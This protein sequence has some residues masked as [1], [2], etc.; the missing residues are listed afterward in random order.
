MDQKEL[1]ELEA[2]CIQEE[3][4]A[5]KAGC[6][7][8]VDGRGFSQAMARGELDVARN[9]LEKAMPLSRILARLCEAPCEQFCIRKNLG[10]S[11]NIS[12][13]ENACIVNTTFKRKILKLPPRQKKTAVIGSGP[14][15]LTVAFDLAKK[16]YQINVYHASSKPGGWLCE[17][18]EE[19]LPGKSRS[20]EISRLVALG[21][22]FNKVPVLDDALLANIVADAVY[23]AQDDVLT[24]SLRNLLKSPDSRTFALS[25]PGRFTGGL[26]QTD[27]PF[28]IITDIFQGREAALSID[29][30]LQGVSLTASR[31]APRSGK[32][33]LFTQTK[34]I[35]CDSR[36]KPASPEGYTLEEACIEA[37]RCIDCQCLECVRHCVYL[38][39]YKAYP[40]VYARRVYN[41]SA[42]VK[43]VHQANRFINTCSLCGQC[44]TLCP[45]DFSMADLC[46]QARRQMV[47]EKRMPPSAHWFAMEEMRSAQDESSLVKHSVGMDSSRWML[48]PGCQLTGI[49][50]LQTMRL[51]ERLLELE[52]QTGI[53]LSCCGVPAHW[54][55]RLEEHETAIRQLEATWIEMGRPAILTGC[56]TCLQ[57]FQENLPQFEAVSVWTVLAREDVDA[58]TS[59]APLALSD[60]CTAR[61][62][63]TTRT[64]VR[65]LLQKAGQQL[66]PLAMSA[67]LTECCGFGGLM[68]NSDPMIARKV[69]EA[70]IAQTD[71]E[72]LTYCAM[73]RDRLAATGKPVLHILDLLFPEVALSAIEPPASISERRVNRR[74]LK[75]RLLSRYPEG[76]LPPQNKWEQLSLAIS[77][78]MANL[79]EKRR[80]LTDDIKRVLFQSEKKEQFFAHGKENRSIASS[81]L[82]E[83]TF[84][85]EYRKENGVYHLLRCWSHR[86]TINPC[87]KPE[88]RSGP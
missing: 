66:A 35:D 1:R 30:Y 53:W 19:V 12:G 75:Q 87:A 14:S 49:R 3:P 40:K 31:V 17:L 59:R 81:R 86:M 13:L 61:H 28:R 10:G 70:R 16:G 57:M 72:M 33:N 11:I 9:L 2:R 34:D 67:E 80:I 7:L 48:F 6:P 54:S 55:G 74:N 41:N 73:C 63:E 65:T 22:H 62:D 77:E 68:E 43:G 45:H 27:H 20:E 50:H 78:E 71:A 23:I 46:L 29:R 64:A 44:E 26:C 88:R 51:Y 56:S 8:G 4:P 79:I 58:I 38:A 69:V 18:P 84:W 5:C 32:T 47:A 83:V 52:P 15:G 37:G 36:V 42:I 24:A 25:A 82:G 76:E 60:P 85:V 39:D 21:V